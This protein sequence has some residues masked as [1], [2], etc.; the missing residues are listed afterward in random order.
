MKGVNNDEDVQRKTGAWQG[1]AF[2]TSWERFPGAFSVSSL[3]YYL[4]LLIPKVSGFYGR[5]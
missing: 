2:E 1:L 3:H 5:G 4:K